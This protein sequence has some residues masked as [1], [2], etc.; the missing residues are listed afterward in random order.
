MTIIHN[1][2]VRDRI[3]EIIEGSG[4]TCVTRILPDAEYLAALDAKLQEDLDKILAE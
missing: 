2:L 3:P 4:K 1:K